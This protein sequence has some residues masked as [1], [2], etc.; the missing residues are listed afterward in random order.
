MSNHIVEREK[1]K[2]KFPKKYEGQKMQ[3]RSE[4]YSCIG[5]TASPRRPKERERADSL[6]LKQIFLSTPQISGQFFQI[7]LEI[8]IIKKESEFRSH[9]L[10]SA[11]HISFCGFLSVDTGEYL[12][13][14]IIII[15]IVVK[16]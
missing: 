13:I 6:S 7:S 9:F 8:L 1:V 16:V 3:V 12:L 5:P 10:K 4:F 2:E 15:V 14:I 11:F